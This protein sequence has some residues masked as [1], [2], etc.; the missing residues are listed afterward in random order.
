MDAR[1]KPEHDERGKGRRSRDRPHGKKGSVTISRYHS[2]DSVVYQKSAQ[3]DQIEVTS[4]A[5]RAELG[6]YIDF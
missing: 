2:I 5:V 4:E 1:V 3:T 6:A